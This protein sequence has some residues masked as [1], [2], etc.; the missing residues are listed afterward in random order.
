MCAVHA[1]N[2]SDLTHF[3]VQFYGECW[4]GQA[5]SRYDAYGK[6]ENCMKGAGGGWTNAV[7]KLICKFLTCLF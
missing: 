5:G 1:R 3:G 4:G 2:R 7:Y 6:S